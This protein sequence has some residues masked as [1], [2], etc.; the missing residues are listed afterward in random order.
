[1]PAHSFE[2][3]L[4]NRIN[5]TDCL[6]AHRL[7]QSGTLNTKN[8]FALISLYRIIHNLSFQKSKVNA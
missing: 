5:I 2:A 4:Q 1:M 6:A 8:I 7:W 3:A